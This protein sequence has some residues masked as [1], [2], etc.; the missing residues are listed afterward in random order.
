[1]QLCLGPHLLPLFRFS[2]KISSS[3]NIGN[4][5][6]DCLL[7]Q[8]FSMVFDSENRKNSNV[9]HDIKH[10][11]KIRSIWLSGNLLSQAAGLFRVIKL[12]FFIQ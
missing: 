3:R 8:N 10:D 4:I 7:Q 12:D 6:K 5:G 9:H 2:N 11:S 1:M